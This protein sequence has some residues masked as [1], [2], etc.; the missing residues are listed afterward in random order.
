MAADPAA[1]R[2]SS[3]AP[4]ADPDDN[5]RVRPEDQKTLA[6]TFGSQ[7]AAVIRLRGWERYACLSCCFMGVTVACL[8]L[9]NQ[10][11]ASISGTI[12][13]TAQVV[14]GALAVAF[15][16][17]V[18]VAMRRYDGETEQLSPSVVRRLAARVTKR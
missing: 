10:V 15:I 16:I 11:G 18:F 14:A 3:L 17:A 1:P 6:L 5:P 4:L 13:H 12:V 2:V 9:A 7:P 8:A